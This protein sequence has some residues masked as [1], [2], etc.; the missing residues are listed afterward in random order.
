MTKSQALKRNIQAL[1]KLFNIMNIDKILS[2]P[3]AAA[4]REGPSNKIVWS[5]RVRLARNIAKTPFPG[6]AKKSIQVDTF[7]NILKNVSPT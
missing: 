1:P 2:S 3:T 6:W 7:Q 5:S 4:E